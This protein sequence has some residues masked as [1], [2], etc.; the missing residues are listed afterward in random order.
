MNVRVVFTLSKF[1]FS[2]FGNFGIL[3]KKANFLSK[4]EHTLVQYT[5]HTRLIRGE[6]Q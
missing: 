6:K 2:N 1:E 4:M 3:Q 5:L